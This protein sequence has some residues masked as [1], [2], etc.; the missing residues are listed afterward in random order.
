M[1]DEIV[2]FAGCRCVAALVIRVHISVSALTDRV[3]NWGDT[4]AIPRCV[5]AGMLEAQRL[6]RPAHGRTDMLSS[7][8][9]ELRWLGASSD[10]S[11]A[12]DRVG[13]S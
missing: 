10:R 2:L 13:K 3:K 9:H 6:F 12:Q 1:I 5:A 11:Q 4:K 8:V 7:L